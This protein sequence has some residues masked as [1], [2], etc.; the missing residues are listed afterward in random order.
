MYNQITEMKHL[1]FC[2]NEICSSDLIII[3][4]FKS[5]DISNF[6]SVS[7]HIL[8]ANQVRK[9]CLCRPFFRPILCENM[10][11]AISGYRKKLNFL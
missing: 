11:I 9:V 5:K 8:E 4:F 2:R 1:V 6:V 3:C 10:K 7:E